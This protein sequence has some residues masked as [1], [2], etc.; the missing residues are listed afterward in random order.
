M[1]KRFAIIVAYTVENIAIAD[2]PLDTNWIDLT[3]VDPQPGIG[4]GYKDGAFTPPPAPPAPPPP[5]PAPRVITKV[6][7]LTRRLT[8]AEFVGILTAA[9]TDVAIEA[10]KYV[11]DAASTIDLDGQNTKDG[12]A[13]LVGKK[14]LTQARADE[15]LNAPVQP[16]E[17]P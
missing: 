16:E 4:W 10:W 9:K 5:P 8:Q 7:M 14:L 12:M 2:E 11:F 17:R 13:L 1:S 15:I 3:S 6:S